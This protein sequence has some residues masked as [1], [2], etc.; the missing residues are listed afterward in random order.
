MTDSKT[1]N[2]EQI[3]H[4]I[5]KGDKPLLLKSI[6]RQDASYSI[7]VF[8]RTKQG[9]NRIIEFLDRNSIRAYAIH[10]DK[11][12]SARN[13]ALKS[14]RD[15]RVQAL[16]I[17][18]IAAKELE[19]PPVTH[20][21]N[22]DMPNNPETYLHRTGRIAKDGNNLKAIT[23]CE[24]I[25]KGFLKDLEKG[26]KQKLTIDENHPY[27]G[28]KPRPSQKKTMGDYEPRSNKTSQSRRRNSDGS[29]N[30]NYSKP[31]SAA[32]KVFN[33]TKDPR[34]SKPVAQ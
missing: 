10:G 17:N 1:H 12:K 3:I 27:H 11:S 25:E 7:L 26:L 34:Y 9:A 2:I 16:I 28:A 6:I 24:M 23:F 31:K 5:A 20:V 19:M 8:A 15:G 13:K 18:D 14:F 22:Y 30:E 21:I 29:I 33:K 32:K 4:F